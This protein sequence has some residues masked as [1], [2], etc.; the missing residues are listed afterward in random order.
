MRRVQQTKVSEIE[1]LG[2]KDSTALTMGNN[3]PSQEQRV[4]VGSLTIKVTSTQ[5]HR[6]YEG[7]AERERGGS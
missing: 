5:A 6:R 7:G 1:R 3:C 2:A 4:M